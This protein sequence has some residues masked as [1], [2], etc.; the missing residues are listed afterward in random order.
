MPPYAGPP[1]VPR[2]G[3]T[4]SAVR[5]LVF[6][7][8]SFALII[9]DH[10]GKW[11]SR[12]RQQ[13]NVLAQPIWMIAALPGQ[14]GQ[15]IGDYW[16]S[17]QALVAENR[18]LHNQLLIAN[19]K[20]TRLQ[21]AARDNAQLRDLLNVAERRG[22]DVQLASI[23]DV[24][25]DPSRQRLILGAGRSDGVF[26]GQP[27]I[28]AG[29]LVGQ[30]IEVAPFHAIVLLVTD[31]DHAVPVLMTRNGVRLIAYGHTDCL[32]LRDI[33]LSAGA[34]VGDEVV[35]SG[36]GGRI[37]AGFPVGQIVALKPDETHA[38]LVG[39]IRPAA[40]LDRGREVLLL[41][42]G[43]NDSPDGHQSAEQ[44]PSVFSPPSSPSNSGRAQSPS[45]PGT[46]D[47]SHR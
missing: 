46:V 8:L 39:K 10:H 22:I 29:G 25:M 38:F 26:V 13:A 7:A 37:P 43:D 14:L 16:V 15:E 23:F 18:T 11:L 21:M 45:R 20:V 33:P 31:P 32:E 34:K 5:L 30:V 4:I 1:V 41:R 40:R 47:E 2:S 12:L 35:T 6:L 36:L 28:D 44:E 17:H 9:L 24:D 3:E 27:V 42:G 19:A